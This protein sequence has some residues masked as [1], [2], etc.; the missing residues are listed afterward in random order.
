MNLQVIWKA[1]DDNGDGG[2][3]NNDDKMAKTLFRYS[4]LAI[5]VFFGLFNVFIYLDHR[6]NSIDEYFS[7]PKIFGLGY[8]ES[9]INP[10]SEEHVEENEFDGCYHVFLDVGTNI[11]NQVSVQMASIL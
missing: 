7:K 11:G 2:D 4:F 6:G 5:L 8:L 3:V 1:S 10:N 9:T